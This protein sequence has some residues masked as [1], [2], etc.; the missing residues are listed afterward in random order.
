MKHDLCRKFQRM[1]KK[2]TRTMTK[3]NR[4]TGYT[5]DTQNVIAFLKTINE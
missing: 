2:A 3:F 4:L 5:V 1:Y